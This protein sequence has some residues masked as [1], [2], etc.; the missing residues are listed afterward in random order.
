MSTDISG[1]SWMNSKLQ[2]TI[3]DRSLLLAS[4]LFTIYLKGFPLI[5][6]EIR[7][8]YHR[9]GADCSIDARPQ[10]VTSNQLRF[11]FLNSIHTQ[12]GE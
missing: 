10:C 5:H 8:M 1:L 2:L 6:N 12:H 11:Q 9:I 4:F 3:D 7:V